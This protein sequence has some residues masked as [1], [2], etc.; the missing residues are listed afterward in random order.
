VTEFVLSL[1][2]GWGLPV[3]ALACLLSCLAI[4]V[5]TSLLM[6]AA[7]AFAAAGLVPLWGVVGAALAGAVVGDQAG[8]ALGRLAGPAIQARLV[9]TPARARLMDRARDSMIGNGMLTVFLTRWLVSPLGPYVNLLAGAAAMSWGR[10][11]LAAIAGE[12]VWVGLYVGLGQAFSGRI[13]TVAAL[14]SDA[15]GLITAILVA[16]LAARMI[17][18]RR[19]P[20]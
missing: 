17:Y 3:L 7:G 2:A 1:L 12:A 8:F 15:T 10:F 9:R 11:T 14:A 5:P 13:E 16:A 18:T 20:G 6:L 19:R 4:P